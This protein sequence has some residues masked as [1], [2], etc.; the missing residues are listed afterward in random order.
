MFTCAYCKKHTCMTDGED[1]PS[2]CPCRD[3]K[4]TGESLCE[5]KD[6]KHFQ[7]AIESA[8][9]DAEGRYML[10]RVEETMLFAHR[11]GVTKLGLAFCVGLS[12]EAL[13]LAKVF[14]Q[15]GFTVESVI[16]KCGSIEKENIGLSGRQKLNEH[17]D[18]M[19]NPIGQALFLSKAGTELNVMLGLCV[20]HDTLFMMNSK[21]PATVLAVKDRV[22]A[23][24][25]LGALYTSS[26]YY[27]RMNTYLADRAEKR[28]DTKDEFSQ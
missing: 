13:K 25:P 11:L 10:N 6:E 4:T 19:C 16:C 9:V 15:N 20:G 26:M 3:E 24:N 28:G 14:E 17:Y 5:T 12:E 18:P 21:V 8:L 2:N 1:Y 23:H 22:L 7:I 27:K